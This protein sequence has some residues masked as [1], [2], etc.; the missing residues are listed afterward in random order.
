MAATLPFLHVKEQP[1]GMSTSNDWNEM[2]SRVQRKQLHFLPQSIQC[3]G[4][5][6]RSF[7]SLY[8][9]SGFCPGK[10]IDEISD[11]EWNN[12]IAVMINAPFHL[13][14]RSLPSM[15]KKGETSFT[16]WALVKTPLLK[17]C[18]VKWPSGQRVGFFVSS[19]QVRT[20]AAPPG[21]RVIHFE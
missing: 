1:T 21:G 3:D 7:C 10:P 19:K 5:F 18:N 2:S 20:P 12:Q 9:V 15:K 13:I 6:A 16:A 14:K 4:N 11:S 17:Y 8:V